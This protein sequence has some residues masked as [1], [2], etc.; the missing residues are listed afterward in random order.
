ME[1]WVSRTY[2]LLPRNVGEMLLWPEDDVGD[3]LRVE[4]WIPTVDG[5]PFIIAAKPFVLGRHVC[6]REVAERK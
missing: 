5:E 4:P 1:E 3:L 6:R 2:S